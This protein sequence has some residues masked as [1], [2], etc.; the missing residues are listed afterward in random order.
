[1]NNGLSDKLKAAFTDTK[2]VQRPLVTYQETKN[3]YWISGFTSGEGCFEVIIL[4]S[5]TNK[6]GSQIVLRFSLSQHSRDEQLMK[7]LISKKIKLCVFFL[8]PPSGQFP[9]LDV[10]VMNF[11]IKI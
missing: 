10:V 7:S 2:P 9:T 6:I 8:K 5:K 4:N 1:M 11:V 3:P